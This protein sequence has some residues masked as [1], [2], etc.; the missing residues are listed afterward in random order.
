LKDSLYLVIHLKIKI[1]DEDRVVYYYLGM[2]KKINISQK[3]GEL[4][5][6]GNNIVGDR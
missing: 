3:I 2:N 5:H 1:F 4:L 6:H